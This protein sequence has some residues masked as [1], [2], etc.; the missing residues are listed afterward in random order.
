[1]TV[2]RALAAALAV[3][4]VA[5]SVWHLEAA[6]SGLVE[7]DF[8]AGTTPVTVYRLPDAHGPLVL[9]AHGFAGS[10]QLMSAFALDLAQAGYTAVTF[11]FEGHGRNPVPMS[12]DID[13]VRGTTQRLLAE[14][15]RVIAAVE[16]RLGDLD[17]LALL[18]HSMA[19]DLI[20]REEERNDRVATVVAV[21]MFSEAVTATQPPHLLIITGEWESG[22]REFARGALRQIDPQAEEGETVRD[23]ATGTVRR[24]VVAPSVEHVSVLY[25]ATALREA[26]AWLDVT[27]GRDSGAQPPA[28][29]GGWIVLMLAGIVLLGWPLAGLLRPVQDRPE[30]IPAGTFLAAILVPA[31]AT[32]LLLSLV[33]TRLL[34]VLVADY[35]AAHFLLYGCL[36]LV[37]LRLRGVNFGAWAMLP[38]LGLVAF[39]LGVFGLALDHYVASFV[40]HAER[41]PIIAAMALGAVPFMLADAVLTE[42]GHAPF[43]RRLAARLLIFASL[44]I[45]VSL[46]FKRLFFLIIALPV[47]LGFFLIFGLMGRW[48]GRR[49]G[50]PM[51]PGI[52][53]GLILAWS[54]GVTFPMFQSLP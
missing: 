7:E 13:D 42:A 9:I 17:G 45:A 33:D 27:F 41:L 23:P 20:V 31:L 39:G 5:V 19:T 29:I 43:W 4:L 51:A 53:L 24:A 2:S 22:L 15:E 8:R 1:M 34:P 37:I 14:M 28:A 30:P 3:V 54:L 16:A 25:S 11:D 48:V 6:R 50:T 35:L 40:P 10:R 32:P 36:A 18:G 47:I 46:D 44:A 21:S 38:T 12:G 52:A 49:T 26:R